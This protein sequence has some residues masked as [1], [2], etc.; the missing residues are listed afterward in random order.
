M[1]QL[2]LVL[3]LGLCAGAALADEPPATPRFDQRQ[4]NQQ[5]RIDQ[6]ATSGALTE[7]EA[8]RLDAQQEHLQRAEDRAKSDGVVTRKERAVLHHRQDHAS[9]NIY[10]K[11]HN[12][13]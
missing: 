10:R 11:K 4:E 5:Q 1:K 2:L 13:R 6:G 9:G 12:R 3:L 7:R 8:V